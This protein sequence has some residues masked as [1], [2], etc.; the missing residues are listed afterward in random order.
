MT[1]GICP[2][3]PQPGS[4]DT[5]GHLITDGR[6][7]ARPSITVQLVDCAVGGD[8]LC[9]WEEESV[10]LDGRVVLYKSRIRPTTSGAR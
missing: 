4:Q 8:R 6:D 10:R 7:V 1:V 2:L 9:G 5:A 3:E